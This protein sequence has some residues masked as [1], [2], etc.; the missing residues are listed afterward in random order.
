[1]G[2]QNWL[3]RCIFLT[4]LLF[5]LLTGCATQKLTTGAFTNVSSIDSQLKRGVSTKM[6][7]QRLLGA[8]NGFG[9]AI[10]PTD[11][12]PREVWYY[13]DIEA[14]DYKSE[15]SFITMNMRQ[16]ILLIFFEKG[17]FNGYMWSTNVGKAESR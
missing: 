4:V 3:G 1:M 2:N 9:G 6:D 8:P 5:Y 10:L 14:T 15:E 16:Q 13:E 12:K 17:V 11:P 7:V